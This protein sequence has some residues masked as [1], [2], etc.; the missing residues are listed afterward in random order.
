MGLYQHV[1]NYDPQNLGFHSGFT[2]QHKS[3]P[4]LESRG[5]GHGSSPL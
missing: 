4:P 2:D 5:F 3:I 1:I